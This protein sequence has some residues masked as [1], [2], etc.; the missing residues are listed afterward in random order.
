VNLNE[1]MGCHGAKLMLEDGPFDVIHA[2]DWLRRCC[3]RAQ[4]QL[5][6]PN[7]HHSCHQNTVAITASSATQDYVSSKEKLLAY[8]AWRIIV[9]SDYM[10]REVEWAL[11]SPGDKIDVI[12]NGIRLEKQ[13]RNDFDA[14]NFRRQFANDSEKLFITSVA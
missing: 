7:F 12:Y 11:Q 2:H 10:R 6:S 3:D 8:N 14:G 13:L 4:A 1:S 5:Q 9:C